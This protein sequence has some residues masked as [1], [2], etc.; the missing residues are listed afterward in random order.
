M[1]ELTA[2]PGKAFSYKE[3]KENVE[4]HKPAALFLVQASATCKTVHESMMLETLQSVQTT[5]ELFCVHT[6]AYGSMLEAGTCLT[7]L[8]TQQVSGGV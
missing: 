8:V 6:C 3:L 2:P 5:N 7:C 1:I 4:K